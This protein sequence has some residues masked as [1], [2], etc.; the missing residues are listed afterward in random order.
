MSLFLKQSCH[1]SL[2]V[3]LHLSVVWEEFRISRQKKQFWTC[4]KL[5]STLYNA[6][7]SVKFNRVSS[8]LWKV[9]RCVCAFRWL[10]LV[11]WRRRYILFYCDVNFIQSPKVC[12]I[13]PTTL[14][15]QLLFAWPRAVCLASCE[16]CDS[17]HFPP[18]SC[19]F[20]LYEGGCCVICCIG[21][22]IKSP[23]A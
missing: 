20:S 4:F 16:C 3:A 2:Y 15:L 11:C 18:L 23:Q 13:L 12:L 10:F 22:P 1:F 21:I 5:I 6:L 19:S 14:L 7:Y 8:T 9:L 17:V